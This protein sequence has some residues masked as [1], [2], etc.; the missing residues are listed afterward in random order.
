MNHRVIHQIE[1]Q[2]VM[3]SFS[4]SYFAQHEGG[5]LDCIAIETRRCSFSLIFFVLD[6]LIIRNAFRK[7]DVHDYN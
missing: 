5:V 6:K 1:P 2:E 3:P 7:F 4:L